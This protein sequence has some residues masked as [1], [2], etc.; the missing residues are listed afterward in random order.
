MVQLPAER[1]FTDTLKQVHLEH[2][3]VLS[4]MIVQQGPV[5]QSN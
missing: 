2:V 3:T 5:L 1:S 4:L